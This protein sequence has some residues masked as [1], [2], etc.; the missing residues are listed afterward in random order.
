M[1]RI[2]KV[3]FP[4]AGRSYGSRGIGSL[5]VGVLFPQTEIRADPG[6]VREYA[7]SVE[8]LG[9]EHL[10]TYEHVVGADPEG[11]EAHWEGP[12]TFRDMF[13]EPFVLFGYLAGVTRRI[14]L[15]TCVLN[16]PQRQTALVAKQ[17][18]EVD[19]LSGG[20]M[21]LGVGVGW[22]TVESEAM[23]ADFA[24]RGERIEEQITVLR[25]LWTQELVSFE[26]RWHRIPRAGLNPLPVQRPIPIWMAGQSKVAVERAGRLG[27][28]WIPGG[29]Y[30][31]SYR[32]HPPLSGGWP[33]LFEHMRAAARASGRDPR[34]IAIN[35][36][37]NLHSRPTPDDW[38]GTVELY[39]AMGASHVTVNTM[40]PHGTEA[41][42]RFTS[43]KDHVDALARFKDAVVEVAGTA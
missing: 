37:L 28:G 9:Y 33:A 12:Y 19:V 22:N 20:R 36:L 24:T 8:G 40:L 2:V 11:R 1:G 21:L 10:V 30:I 26:G 43:V 15:G 29:G 17:A 27:D 31:S 23:G 41:A 4:T 35:V 3:A 16:L 6:A 25:A 14:R 7:Q 18:A 34:T 38:R 32:R 42:R 5:K 13:H 39:E